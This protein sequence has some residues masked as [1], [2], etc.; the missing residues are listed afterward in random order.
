MPPSAAIAAACPLLPAADPSTNAKWYCAQLGFGLV[1][2][3]GHYVIVGRDGIEVHFWQTDD[4]HLA[5]NSGAYFRCADVD[6]LYE[7]FRG[8]S[9]G[10]RLIAPADRDWGMREFYVVDPEGNLLRFGQPVKQSL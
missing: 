8:A 3:H 4:K 9:Q 10:G 1:A 6:G 5:A 7:T 2:D